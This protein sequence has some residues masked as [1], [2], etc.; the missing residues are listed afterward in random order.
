MT[1]TNI[2]LDPTDKWHGF[3]TLIADVFTSAG[4]NIFTSLISGWVLSPGRRTITQMICAGDPTN[5]KQHD[6]YH[7]FVRCGRWSMDKLWQCM[8]VS[9]VLML[10]IKGPLVI[11][12]DD[13]LFKKTGRKIQ[14]TGIF[15]DAVRST[16]SKVVYSLGLNLVVATLRVNAPWGGC[17]IGLPIGVRLHKKGGPTT[18]DLA[19][20]IAVELSRWFKDR[21]LEIC[22]DGA[23]ASLIGRHIPNATITSR[24]RKDAALFEAA[25]EKTLKPGR[26]RC[27]GARLK[28]PDLISKDLNKN[29]FTSREFNCRGKQVQTLLWSKRV[30][31]YAVDKTKMVTLLLSYKVFC[32]RVMAN[33][34]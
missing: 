15:R 19:E 3:L 27:R 23:Y 10:S 8:V 29:E 33:Y 14:G 26:P 17:P 28:S 13:T 7:R 21:H 22:A 18:V 11:D 6:A 25:P 34:S 24:M 4:F 9:I 32:F 5:K 20:V 30:L 16:K 2:H 31:W 12:I 1:E